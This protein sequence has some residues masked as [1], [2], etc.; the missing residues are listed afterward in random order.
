MGM[1]ANTEQRYWTPDDVWALP[2]DGKRYECID[3]APLVTPSPRWSHQD[4]VLALLERLRPWVKAQGVGR[5]LAAPADARQT[6]TAL[7]QPDVFVARPRADGSPAQEKDEDLRLHLAI[8][9]LSPSTARRDRTVKRAFCHRTGMEYWIVDPDARVVE[10]WLPGDARPDIIAES[11]LRHPVGANDPL[12]IDLV[13][14]FADALGE[15]RSKR[16]VDGR[17]SR[18]AAQKRWP[19]AIHNG[20]AIERGRTSRAGIPCGTP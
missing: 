5:L 1:P 20:L 13:A 16:K 10:R 6:L 15:L 9:I 18:C 4:V 7:V 3:G 19:R 8:E 17:R 14:L 12:V 2:D 11:L